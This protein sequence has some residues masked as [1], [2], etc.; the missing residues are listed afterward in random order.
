M[1]FVIA[2]PCPVSVAV[3][4]WSQLTDSGCDGLIVP[5]S[6]DARGRNFD[7]WIPV[8]ALGDHEITYEF[9]FRGM[10]TDEQSIHTNDLSSECRV[11]FS[12]PDAPECG[13]SRS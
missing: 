4:V 5:E 1:A 6:P 11:I 9:L 12:R 2:I 8:R 7:H 10:R 3:P 13:E